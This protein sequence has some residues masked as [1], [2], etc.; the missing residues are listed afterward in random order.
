MQTVERHSREGQMYKDVAQ[1]QGVN[2]ALTHTKIPF[3]NNKDVGK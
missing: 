1:L 2:K 3:T